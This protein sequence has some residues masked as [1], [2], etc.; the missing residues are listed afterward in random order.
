MIFRRDERE[1]ASVIIKEITIA[2][3]VVCKQIGRYIRLK[4]RELRK[5]AVGFEIS[6]IIFFVCELNYIF[7]RILYRSNIIH[8]F[9]AVRHWNFFVFIA[10]DKKKLFRIREFAYFVCRYRTVACTFGSFVFGDRTA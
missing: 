9:H 1:K 10:V 2:A 4:R 6:D 8:A 3:I 7:A 5:R